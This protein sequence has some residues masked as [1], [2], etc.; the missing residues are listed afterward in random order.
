MLV[1]PLL[2]HFE[3]GQG[4]EAPVEPLKLE[5][6][7]PRRGAAEGEE[8]DTGGRMTRQK[9]QRLAAQA[10]A[11]AATEAR[12]ETARTDNL[13]RLGFLMA[14]TMTL[15]NLVRAAQARRSVSAIAY[16]RPA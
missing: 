1:E 2:P 7:S 8:L 14:V 12:I 10:A 4:K 6:A 16:A 13:L 3:G 11:T 15:H 9:A 5:P